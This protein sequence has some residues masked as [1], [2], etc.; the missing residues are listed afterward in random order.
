M[1]K[2]KQRERRPFGGVAKDPLDLRDLMYESTLQ[3]LPFALDNRRRVPVVLDQ[4]REGACTGFGLA[5]VV[6]YLQYNRQSTKPAQKKQLKTVRHGASARMLYEMAKRYDEWDGENYEGS[7]IRG[8]MKGWQRHGVCRWSEWPYDETDPGRLSPA[9]Q[10]AALANPLGAYF[11]VR[12]LHLNQMHSALSE[13]GI[14]Y[15]S[16]Q[17]HEGWYDIDP[18]TGKIPY[19]RRKTGGHAFAIVGYDQDGFWVQNSWGPDWGAAGFCH[20]SYD[21]WLENAYDCWVARL[22]VPTSSIAVRGEADR[23]RVSTFDFIPHESVVLSEIRPHFINLGNDGM[24]SDSGIYATTPQDVTDVVLDGF[25]KA[26]V[27]W[28]RSRK[29]MLYAHGGLNNEKASAS[30]VASLRPYFLANRIYPVHFMWETG[31]AESLRSIL[32][33]V[34]RSRRFQ[35]W[36]DSLKDRFFDLIDEGIELAGGRLGQPVWSQMKQNAAGATENPDGGARFTAQQIKAAFDDMTPRPELHLVGHSA[37]SIFLGHLLPFL[38]EIGLPV[39]TL[40]LFA[41]ACTV[42]LF[43]DLIRPNLKG[44]VERFTVI[45]LTDAVERDDSVA[46]VYNK[47]LLYLVSEAFETQRKAPLLGMETFAGAAK[48]PKKLSLPTN[49][50]TA[51]RTVGPSFG[52]MPIAS[53]STTHGGFDNDGETL[54][55]TLRIIRG[56]KTLQRPFPES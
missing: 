33:D 16:A 25:Q 23:S 39:K 35:G 47:S 27:E 11:R 45:N 32:Q 37:G 31:L 13:A 36:R 52:N 40:T 22:G 51:I 43:D 7:S 3:E 53:S 2:P 20:I 17:V 34:F 56:T 8:A 38:A 12:H 30:R 10:I 54:N 19:G 48:L 9:R 41:P 50:K 29:L 42:E 46:A 1:A 18:A 6:N 4:G 24:F 44:N 21:D 49:D 14:L 28:K 15:A 5:A 26:S 55:S